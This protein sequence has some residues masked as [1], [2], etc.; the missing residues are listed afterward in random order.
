MSCVVPGYSHRRCI[1]VLL[2]VLTSANGWSQPADRVNGTFAD[3][4]SLELAMED[5]DWFSREPENPLWSHDSK[6]IYFQRKQAGTEIREWFRIVIPDEIFNRSDSSKIKIPAVRRVPLRDQ[7]QQLPLNGDWNDDHTYLVGSRNGDLFLY[8]KE[9]SEQTQLTRTTANESRAQFMK[10]GRQI[11]FFRDGVLL[12]RD[13]DSGLETEPAIV[14][15]DDQP[16][17]EASEPKK[18]TDRNATDKNAQAE[19]AAA[20]GRTSGSFVEEQEAAL[21][22]YLRKQAAA[23]EQTKSLQKQ[24]SLANPLDVDEPFYLG[25]KRQL[26]SQTLSRDGRWLAIVTKEAGASRSSRRDK[27]LEWIRK[28]GYLESRDVRALVGDE[29]EGPEELV[30]IDLRKRHIHW[31]PLD[32]LPDVSIDRLA[33]LKQPS[34]GSTTGQTDSELDKS[35]AADNSKPRDLT[36]RSVDFSNDSKHLL[37]QCFSAD[38]KDRWILCQPTAR[39]AN[40]ES[41]KVLHHRYDPAWIN[42]TEST[43]EWLGR[44]PIV[45]FLSEATGYLHLHVADAGTGKV[46]Q[47]TTGNF[48]VTDPVVTPEADRVFVTINKT[49]PGEY[50]LAVVDI[51]SGEL[52]QC[53]SLGGVNS[54]QL[55]PEYNRA[56]VVHSEALAPPELILVDLNQNA[57]ADS[58]I[59]SDM[60]ADKAANH[61]QLT[62]FSTTQFRKIKWTPP[63]FETVPSRTGSEIFSRLYLPE[64]VPASIVKHSKMPAT[65]SAKKRPA[66]VFIHGAGY[67]QNAHKGWS[68]YFREFMFHTILTRLGYVV[69]DMD[70]R[71]SKGYGRNWRTAIYRQMGTPELE[72]LQD[73]VKW[74]S[75]HHNV[76]PDRIGVYG[77]SYGGFM[78]LMALFRDPDLFA[79][80]AALRPVTDWAHYNHG[81]TSNILN[82]PNEDPE[83]YKNSSPIYFA[84]GLQNPLLICH[85]M[86]DDNVFFKDTVRLAQRLIELKKDHWNVAMYPVEP[87]G[88]RQPSSWLDEYRRILRLFE[89][90]LHVSKPTVP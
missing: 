58:A 19:K 89:T 57:A 45:Y 64:D 30:V 1:L 31:V 50:E 26:V 34:Q 69:L 13:L 66:V 81:Y 75:E 2:L 33:F 80:G 20:T 40:P 79:C 62:K 74:L 35:K 73:G 36:I 42:W 28:D 22:D 87:H 32:G 46:R 10:N 15:F 55:S 16:D 38:N 12:L 90:N 82:T 48:E 21:F 65:E 70:Y 29:K 63:H 5:P 60:P 24:L 77:G 59:Q 9:N 53:T 17:D 11:Q 54:F 47:L 51:K 8:N 61:I 23:L 14:R 67:L 7:S 43:V 76:D 68:G 84:D 39:L 78:T 83:A 49:H 37:F 88:F 41:L 71:A 3:G 18:P 52:K 4:L 44:K 6:R 72:D 56:V 27:M 86:V 85:G 25:R